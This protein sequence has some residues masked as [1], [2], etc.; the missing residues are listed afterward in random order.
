VTDCFLESKALFLRSISSFEKA[1]ANQ[2]VLQCFW[3]RVMEQQERAH[4][5][6]D[7]SLPVI[8]AVVDYEKIKR[9]GEGTYGVVCE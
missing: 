7:E 6:G 2:Q 4:N 1:Y 3:G 8:D 5:P 9:I